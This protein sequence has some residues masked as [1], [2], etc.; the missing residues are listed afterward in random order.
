MSTTIGLD[1]TIIIGL[2]DAQDIWHQPAINLL[3]VLETHSFEP[4]VFDCVLSEA[5]STLARRIHEKR[6]VAQLSSLMK[7]LK[8][9]F[10]A[11]SIVW[12]YPD[13]P[14][15]YDDVIS[16][17]EQSSGELNFNDAL[18]ALSC[19]ARGIAFLASFDKDFDQ[20]DWLTRISTPADLSV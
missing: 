5:I 6:R 3:A 7:G 1:T 2:L 19:R 15:L 4:V 12:L 17:V 18:I 16:L 20:V 10:P 13:L 11:K 9:R 8:T 14:D